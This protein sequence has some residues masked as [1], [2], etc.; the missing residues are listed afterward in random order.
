MDLTTQE[1]EDIISRLK[2]TIEEQKKIIEEMKKEEEEINYLP[3]LIGGL[4]LF[5]LLRFL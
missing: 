3:Y 5:A 1:Q 4:S 2:L